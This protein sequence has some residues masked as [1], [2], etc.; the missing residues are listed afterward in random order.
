MEITT[1]K[2]R[3]LSEAW[4]R[5]CRE[6]L[7]HGYEYTIDKG[8]FEGH[9]RKEFDFVVIQIERPWERPLT[10]S[11]PVGVTPPTTDEYIENEYM[12]YLMTTEKGLNDIYSYGTDLAPQ[13]E[14]VIKRYKTDGYETNQL[15]MRV[16]NKDSLWLEHSQCLVYVDTRIRY[17]ALHFVTYFRSWD[18]F[19]GV[20]VN[21][22]GLQLLKEY[23]SSQIGV[24]DGEL[25]A[26]SKGL[27]LY[28]FQ[29]SIVKNIVG[30]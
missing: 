29:I 25:I 28:D 24:K 19:S 8:S 21:L 23:M 11:V 13:I 22:G 2:A 4:F 7:L 18:L 15:C 3:N 9:K 26:C 30:I 1:I 27:H 5:C 14:E 12:L 16:G 6:L 17:G 20:C 10:P